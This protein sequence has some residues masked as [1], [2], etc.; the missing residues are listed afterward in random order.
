MSSLLKKI[1]GPWTVGPRGPT[2]RGPT[3][4]G[5]NCPGRRGVLF[6]IEGEVPNPYSKSGPKLCDY[7]YTTKKSKNTSMFQNVFGAQSA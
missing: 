7:K 1:L 3:V 2:A 6:H 5:P 4:Q